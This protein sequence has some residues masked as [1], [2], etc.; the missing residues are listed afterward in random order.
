[1]RIGVNLPNG[2]PGVDGATVLAWARRADNSVLTSV[3]VPDRLDYANIDPV[4]TL[5]AAAGATNRV[6]LLA[7][8]LLPPYRPPAV[9][10]KEVASL[11]TFAPGRLT[12]GV[13]AGAR[14]VDYEAAGIAW[15]DRGRLVDEAVAT[16]RAMETPAEFPQSL[17]PKP[18]MRV[19]ILVGGASK[20]A[21]ARMLKYGDG[22]I[23]GGVQ[24]K[25]FGFEVLAA[26]GA[27][28]AA[29]RVGK[30]RIVAGFWCASD[31]AWDRAN[32]WQHDYFVKGG[33]PDFVRNPITRGRDQLRADIEAY[34]QAGAEEIS[35]FPCV[36]D[37]DE[38]EF[39][40]EA[41]KDLATES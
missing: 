7:N 29:G 3:G 20:P 9:W 26:R 19:P 5:A 41:V 18:P 22:Y 27:W 34:A 16:Y 10:A 38:L 12:I 31:G 8:V 40:I 14:P 24:P 33:P 2:V 6:E 21:L 11:A 25:Y 39:V 17:G 13:A 15:A 36:A 35:L 28:E 30:P 37:L 1:M 4:V 23:G 32:A